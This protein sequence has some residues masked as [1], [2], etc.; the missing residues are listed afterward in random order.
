LGDRGA[1]TP[2]PLSLLA[3]E[4]EPSGP[5][6]AALRHLYVVG[7]PVTGEDN[8][9][10]ALRHRAPG[11]RLPDW[12]QHGDGLSRAVGREPR[13]AQAHAV[14]RLREVLRQF[15]F[16][17]GAALVKRYAPEP[18]TACMRTMSAPS[19]GHTILVAQMMPAEV[20]SG[21]WRR[22]REGTIT[23]RGARP[24]RLLV[25]RHTRREYL[26]IERSARIV[27]GAEDLLEQHPLPAYEAL[28]RASALASK[29]RC[30]IQAPRKTT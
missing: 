12:G 8:L 23:P 3:G 14:Q 7:E 2:S 13:A 22:V 17:D 6:A 10:K 29:A 11:D 15:L 1:L 20:M 5:A 27:Q 25:D 9:G 26:V 4:G 19:A 18:G 24:I 28:Q 21:I 30:Y 16:R